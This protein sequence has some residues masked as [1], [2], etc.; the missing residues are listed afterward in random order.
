MTKQGYEIEGIRSHVDDTD[1]QGTIF[2][3]DCPE[4]TVAVPGGKR[5]VVLVNHLKSKG[6]GAE[7]E[8][9]AKRKRQAERVAAI[10]QRLRNAGEANVV[11]VGDLNDT[12]DSA[13][14]APL[15]GTTDLKDISA[16]PKFTSDGRP[17]TFGDGTKKDKFDYILLAPALYTL[18]TGGGVF[19]KGVW[20][21]KDGKLWPHYPTMTHD[22]QAASDHAA[23][24]ADLNL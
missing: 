6:F 9:N 18:V 22:Y 5:L 14:L 13:P 17:G 1:A 8:N 19:R 16:H 20:G 11:V 24:F 23:I 15:L 12:P 3:R 10:Y 7:A 4:Y 2:S 21:G